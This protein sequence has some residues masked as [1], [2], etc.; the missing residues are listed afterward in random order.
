MKYAIGFSLLLIGSQAFASTISVNPVTVEPGAPVT[1]SA[2][3]G[4]TADDWLQLISKNAA[5]N[6]V[7]PD[8]R[9]L[10][11]SQAKPARPVVN[12][13]IKIV[14]PTTAGAYEAR[15][16]LGGSR[17]VAS[18]AS[19]TVAAKAQP[20]TGPAGPPGAT[21]PQG[22][23]GPAGATG[24]KGDIG[25]PGPSGGPPGPAGAAGPKGDTGPAGAAGATGAAGA[26]G[27]TGPA[28]P[29]G[30]VGPAGPAGPPGPKGNMAQ[31]TPPA[32]STCARGDSYYD[33]DTSGP[34]ALVS[35]WVCDTTFKW[36]RL[37]QFSSRRW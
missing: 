36:L 33:I 37:P 5:D 28:G 26:K 19:L 6:V 18:R 10:N 27:A 22:P 14:A 3:G 17:S 34:E 20:S 35:I 7:S 23:P 25:P 31:G 13:D 8:W 1:L 4:S 24:A 2:R 32:G 15:M 9:Y 11:N 12:A 16:Y 29:A 21:G 30:A